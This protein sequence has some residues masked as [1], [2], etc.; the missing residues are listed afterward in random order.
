LPVALVAIKPQ[1]VIAEPVLVWDYGFIPEAS[2]T[3]ERHFIADSDDFLMI[4]PQSRET[5]NH[6]I[7]PGWISYDDI[8]K[9]LSMW[10]TKEQRECGRQLLKIH[11]ED[12]PPHLNRVVEESR[13]YMAQIYSRLSPIPQP[14]IG[15]SYLGPWF[16][17][18][19]ERMRGNNS[20]SKSAENLAAMRAATAQHPARTLQKSAVALSAF[21]TLRA[22]YRRIF[23]FAPGFRR[24]HPLW[25]DYSYVAGKVAE[26]RKDPAERILWVGSGDSLFHRVLKDRVDCSALLVQGIR[27]AFFEKAPYDVC[28][29]ELTIEQSSRLKEIYSLI[30]P[31]MKDGSNVI[32]H[33]VRKPPARG[34]DWLASCGE[35]FPDTDTS[36]IRFFGTAATAALRGCYTHAL[37]SFQSRQLLWGAISGAT[38]LF[39]APFVWW[40]NARAVRRDPSIY[41]PRWTSMVIDFTVRRRVSLAPK[42]L[43]QATAASLA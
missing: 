1:R 6:M 22:I 3:A 10:T 24:F 18:A 33:V 31:L 11:A 17:G 25:V 35:S 36:E 14:H 13:T 28:L 2:P 7:Q 9:N 34:S 8:A 42:T 23:G 40:A 38:L 4:E 41:T 29:C 15:H 37:G 19:K 39:L 32:V 12:L 26:W 20:V 30:R 21:G 5:G 43:P 16:D 27:G